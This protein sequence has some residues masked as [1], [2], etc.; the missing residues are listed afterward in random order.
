MSQSSLKQFYQ[1]QLQRIASK[2]DRQDLGRSAIVFSPHPDDETLGCGGT[3]IRKKKAGADVKI[4]FMTDGGGSHPHL[5][6]A[7]ELKSIRA[8][9]AIAAAQV[10]GV[11]QKDV[12][13]LEFPDGALNRY[14]EQAIDKVK[15]ILQESQPE[16]IYIPYYKE[17]PS[18]HFATNQIAVAAL[19][20][21]EF[22]PTIY[23]YPIWF[24]RQLPWTSL[25][26]S[27]REI[28]SVIKS[29]LIFGFGLGLLKD[30]KSTV[31]IGDVLEL[32]H[33]ALEKHGTQMQRFLP[34]PAWQTLND[35]SNGEFIAC[36]F[37]KYEIFRQSRF[38]AKG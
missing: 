15:Y 25:V 7:E 34:T 17:T 3:I 27:R 4:V 23:E 8:Q 38:L 35:V 10:L 28:L 13:F 11:E 2:C 14:R 21:Y 31:Y 24:W 36:F 33:T 19:K 1:Q 18:D 20:T 6:S 16:E 37:Q 32:K 29:S 9:E 22:I 30:F 5:M 12:L 26:G